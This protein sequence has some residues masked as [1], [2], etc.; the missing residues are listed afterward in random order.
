MSSFD[1][2]RSSAHYRRSPYTCGASVAREEELENERTLQLYD[3]A[4]A[5]LLRSA[6]ANSIALVTKDTYKSA[7]KPFLKF[8]QLRGFYPFPVNATVLAAYVVRQ[9]MF[10]SIPS[11]RVYLSAIR[12]GQIDEG[13]IWSLEGNQKV[14]RAVRYVRRRYGE[15]GRALK[16]PLSLSTLLAMFEFIPGWPFPQAMSHDAR[17]FVTASVLATT[18][19]LRGGEFLKSKGNDQSC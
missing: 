11:L 16:V 1:K 9:A 6:L 14:A 13:M 17:L 4:M 18:G 8:C 7:I 5:S 19:F 3:P 12:S 15:P 2:I 10:V